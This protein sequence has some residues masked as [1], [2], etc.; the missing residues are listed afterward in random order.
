MFKLHL[1]LP[2]CIL[3]VSILKYLR[4]LD[5][6]SWYKETDEIKIHR[7]LYLR[8]WVHNVPSFLLLTMVCVCGGV[9]FS[10]R[11]VRPWFPKLRACDLINCNES[12]YLW[13]DFHQKQVL[14]KWYLL[15]C[16][17]F[18]DKIDFVCN[19]YIFSFKWGFCEQACIAL[20]Y[21]TVYLNPSSPKGFNNPLKQFSPWCS[22]MHSKGKNCSGYL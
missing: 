12:E 14:E 20:V 5:N 11:Y 21:L 15:N 4:S 6:T 3:I 19:V 22:K 7:D 18:D 8:E 16:K 10:S 1:L 13:A 17:L 9:S 2:F